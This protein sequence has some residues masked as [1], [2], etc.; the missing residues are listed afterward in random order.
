MEKGRPRL[1]VVPS[2]WEENG[3]LFWPH[4]K[5]VKNRA[6]LIRDETSFPSPSWN[7]LD[8]V[9]K[10][11]NLSTYTDAEK[12]LE[13]MENHTDT[14]NEPTATVTYKQPA[15]ALPAYN[16]EDMVQNLVIILFMI[17]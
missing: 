12:E 5:K 13:I 16:F 9:V 10:R 2:V 17:V 6:R 15:V 8:C 1:S 14:D 11:N 4:E 3:K 7:I